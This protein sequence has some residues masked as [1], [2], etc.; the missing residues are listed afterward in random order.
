MKQM[1]II[2]LL[3][4]S[5]C[6]P[7]EEV[8]V[9]V[10]LPQTGISASLGTQMMRGIEL[11]ANET[12]SPLKLI[13]ED[14]QCDAKAGV[15]ATQ[16][17]IDVNEVD[18]ILGPI[19]TVAILS[20]AQKVEESKV[21]R[22]TTGMVLQKTANAGDWHFSF[23]PEMKHQMT[24]IAEYAKKQGFT[25]IGAIAVNDD[26]GRESINEL[27]LALGKVGIQVVDEEYFDKPETDF[28]THV[29]KVMDKK[30]DALYM[31]GYAA[32]MVGIVKQSDEL[33]FTK[34]ILTWN[35]FQ[36]PA[37]LQLGKLAENVVYTFPEDPRELPVKAAFKT[38]FRAAFGTDPGLYAANAYDSYKIL[39]DVVKQ[40]GKDKS[41]IKSKLYAIKDYEGANGFITVDNRG[42][43]QRAEVSLK[44][45]KNGSFVLV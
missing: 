9:G 17:L 26:L 29:A 45:V 10:M 28:K 33:G 27:K 16:K 11:A 13:I 40:C 20:S 34:P 23:L 35:L 5:A 18:A 7:V 4:L 22:I 42:V 37:V 19:C 31:L 25:S 32:N 39:A 43:G 3:V 30:P 21:P 12:G 36:D 38:R 1:I 14:D 6:A 44:T 15:T 2:A 8:K 41:C 24:A